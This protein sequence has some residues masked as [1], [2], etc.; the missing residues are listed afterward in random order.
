MNKKDERKKYT[1]TCPKCGYEQWCAKSMA[2][3]CGH[4]SGHGSCLECK[5]F[6][7]LKIVPNLDGDKAE[8]TVYEEFIKTLKDE[9][10]KKTT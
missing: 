8:A 9:H 4:N 6:L 10:N 3:E 5:T 7:H 1:F 2:M